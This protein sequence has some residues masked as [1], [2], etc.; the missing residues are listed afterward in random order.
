MVTLQLAWPEAALPRCAGVIVVPSLRRPASRC[1]GSWR[2]PAG[3][4]L[5]L[6]TYVK[7]SAQAVK[8]DV[9]RCAAFKRKSSRRPPSALRGACS[10]W[11]EGGVVREGERRDA[12]RGFLGSR[13]LSAVSSITNDA[14]GK[15]AHNCFSRIDE[16]AGIWNNSLEQ[17]VTSDTGGAHSPY[18]A[19][20]GALS[21]ITG[22]LCAGQA[23]MQPHVV[24]PDSVKFSSSRVASELMY[25][26]CLSWCCPCT[27]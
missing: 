8:P 23:L 21:L 7:G 2:P 15:G 25:S 9:C 3:A 4:Q 24:G 16:K 13:H 20:D 18:K 11:A 6:H 26:K 27:W 10:P 17:A 22:F 14:E 19:G 12:T 5:H 1:R